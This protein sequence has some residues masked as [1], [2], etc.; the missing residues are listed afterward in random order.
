MSS[1]VQPHAEIEQTL[2]QVPVFTE[3]PLAAFIIGPQYDLNRYNV[4]DEK[5]NTE[6]VN[7]T[8]P[9][10]KNEYQPDSDV[11]YAYPSKPVGSVVDQDY[12]KVYMENILAQY[13]PN[14]VLGTASDV[15]T[16]VSIV[17]SSPAA[18][19][20]NRV[21]SALIYQTL[22][23]GT[24]DTVFSD[25]DVAIGDYIEITDGTPAHA[26]TSKITGFVAD[27]TAAAYGTES[28]DAGNAAA[29]VAKFDYS[30]VFTGSGS[31][32]ANMTHVQDSTAYVGYIELGVTTDVYTIECTTGGLLAAAKFTITSANNVFAAKTDQAV[33]TITGDADIL[34]L[35]DAGG[36]NIRVDWT[37]TTGTFVVGNKWTV[38]A[39]ALVTAVLPVASGTYTGT[40]DLTYKLTV[41]RGGPF[42]TGS[43]AATCAQITIT[44]SDI[45]SSGPVNVASASTF[46]VGN[47]AALA[48]F[49]SAI[50][51]GGLVLG[52]VFY[53]PVTA[54]APGHIHT[55]VFQD[56]LTADLLAGSLTAKLY[57]SKSSE[58]IPEIRPLTSAVNWSTAS[59]V[60][61]IESGITT[62]D[63][64]LTVG[65][66]AVNLD[67]RAGDIFVEHRDLVQDNV[68]AIGSVTSTTDVTTKLGTI[69]PD[70]AIAQGA[71]LAVLNS[72][73]VTV[74]YLAVSTDDLT[75]YTRA[76]DIAKNS[77]S[78]YS[79]VPM[80]W[81]STIQDAVVSHVNAMSTPQ[82]AKWRI[83]WLSKPLVER[84]TK[85]LLN[86]SNANW[87]A[88]MTDDPVTAS[89]DY[90]LVTIA[91]AT[92]LTDGIRVGDIVK[93]NYRLDTAGTTIWDEYTIAEVRTE[94]TCITAT[95]PAAAI[96][97]AVKV[98]ID[99]VYTAD[100]Q[101]DNL[102]AIGGG[103]D[104]RRVRCI[105]PDTVKSGSTTLNGY[106]VA[107]A[108]AGLRS[109]VVPHQGLT[110]IEVLGFDDLTKSVI[111]FTNE[112]L[113]RLAE[114]GV[115]ILTQ[116]VVGATPYTRHQLTTD[117]SGLNTSEDSVT[118][119]VDS[120]SYGM[121]AV[122]DPFIGVYNR[123]TETLTLLKN[124]IDNQLRYR[125]TNTYTQRTGNQL[126][127][128]TIDFV[129]PNATFLDRVD[130]QVT[131]QVP[132]PYNYITLNFIV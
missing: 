118:T 119:N 71:Y 7:P 28:A 47:H 111:T 50:C 72:A 129:T 33:Q 58:L 67:I 9:A 40:A 18:Y 91:G 62:Q 85:Y 27:I 69:D 109:G 102:A 25:R 78:V 11:A 80:S 10:L 99:R 54:A 59:D 106:F 96:S 105:F 128:Y 22:N 122:I 123:N 127:G 68:N 60:I 76:L 75:G 43:N 1:Y 51:N 92:L 41:T 124:A 83:A 120:I 17:G 79:F 21:S 108:L 95:G 113:N 93:I 84:D 98:E 38:Q 81:V 88:T 132:Y 16:K 8:T 53:V 121:Q 34:L 44:S 117:F 87:T 126:N 2:T 45:D 74:F 112:Q 46:A 70:N 131:L 73:S 63:A 82:N 125:Q 94:T 42:Y 114:Q 32:P 49:A 52:D 20:P 65:G 64:D 56:S 66:Q 15:V 24:R 31:E 107:A 19:Y 13:F 89:T 97:P 55:I 77:R 26:I 30:P 39:D 61:T 101:I 104:N 3:Q 29:H 130:V 36:N 23:G 12:V 100:E 103:F 115:W 35:D 4:A 5:A 6:V 14:T 86:S 57:L 116:S 110:N 37:G 48:S 90:T